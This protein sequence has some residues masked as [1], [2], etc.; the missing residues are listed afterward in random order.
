M[1][2]SK[3][4]ATGET[5]FVNTAGDTMT[6]DLVV[7]SQKVAIGHTSPSASDWNNNS[8]LLHVKG[9]DTD[10]AIVKVSSSNADGVLAVGDNHL[11]FGT[12][13]NDPV[14][15]YTNASQR[16]T[17]DSD[18]LKFGTDTAAT[19]ALNK[20]E[21]GSFTYTINVGTSGYVGTVQ[22]TYTNTA[23]YTKIGKLVCVQY[24]SYS[25]QGNAQAVYS[26]TLPFTSARD[27]T[28]HVGEARGSQFRYGGTTISTTTHGPYGFFAANDTNVFF[29][30]S[31]TSQDFSGFVY[32]PTSSGSSYP[33]V[34]VTYQATT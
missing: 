6:G 31:D 23:Y 2:K 9:N 4:L 32:Y 22:A 29:G 25:V 33:K 12:T 27:G 10:G 17:V 7:N 11:Q 8:K 19:N 21:E 20:Y 34:T 18:G 16:L 5:R 26:Y 24:P 30:Y 1:G 15:I 14:K 28:G 13:S 3:D